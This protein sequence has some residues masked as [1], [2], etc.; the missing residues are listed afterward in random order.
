MLPHPPRGPTLQIKRSAF[1]SSLILNTPK[2]PQHNRVPDGAKSPI[3]GYGP[4]QAPPHLPGP[5]P[6]C[7]SKPRGRTRTPPARC[8]L[9]AATAAAVKG[10]G[11]PTP[12]TLPCPPA[13]SAPIGYRYTRRAAFWDNIRA[14]YWPRSGKLLPPTSG[15][16]ARGA[17]GLCYEAG[18]HWLLIFATRS[19][20]G[21]R[22]GGLP[23]DHEVR[24]P[25]LEP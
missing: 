21:W 17:G 25:V 9:R 1:L 11:A 18:L 23:E 22:P 7:R 5:R 24:G 3:K 2:P 6:R 19:A 16:A 20:I 15:I 14:P 12:L 10:E 8:P 13:S 4:G